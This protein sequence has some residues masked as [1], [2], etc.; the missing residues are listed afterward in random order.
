MR[1]LRRPAAGFS[2]AAASG[3][4]EPAASAAVEA[5]NWRRFMGGDYSD[6]TRTTWHG[7][8]AHVFLQKKHGL[9]A[10]ATSLSLRL[11][12]GVFS[13]DHQFH[14]DRQ[15]AGLAVGE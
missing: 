14:R 5:M 13:P 8:P 11:P 3:T 12:L 7:L 10:R 2:W 15:H 4:M 1:F 6:A 9:A